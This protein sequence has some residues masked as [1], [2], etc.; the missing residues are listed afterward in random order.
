MHF[1]KIIYKGLDKRL[2]LYKLLLISKSKKI[3]LQ[4][5]HQNIC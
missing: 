4:Y 5:Y 3:L 1:N 2:I